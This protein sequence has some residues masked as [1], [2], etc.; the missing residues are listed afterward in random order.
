MAWKLSRIFI[1]IAAT[2]LLTGIAAGQDDPI[3]TV[4]PTKIDRSS[5][6]YERL[7]AVKVERDTRTWLPVPE[8]I[9]VLDSTRFSVGQHIYQVANVRAVKPKRICK[10]VEGGRWPCGRM[11]S[12]FLGNLVRG[13]RL[14]CDI[15]QTGKNLMLRRC[16]VGTRD[17]AGAIIAN[18]YGAAEADDAL[19]AVQAE[20]QSTGSKG[21]WRN[22]ECAANFDS[23]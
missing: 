4:K 10:A 17:V 3:W 18:G 13:K 8:R 15:E 14:L 6:R 16:V 20:A 23:C 1:A 2:A 22:P 12:I 19:L 21:L 11:A 5:Q 7:P 9:K